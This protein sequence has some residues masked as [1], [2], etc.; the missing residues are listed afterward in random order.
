MKNLMLIVFATLAACAG[1]PEG[2]QPVAGFDAKRYTGKWYEIARLDNRFERGLDQITA[3]YNLSEDG[4]LHVV[5]SGR[6]TATNRREYAY[7]KACFTGSPNTGSLKVSFFGPFYGGYHIIELD[8][9]DYHYAMISGSGGRDYL[10]ILARS[11]NLN[12]TVLNFL[13]AK[14]KTLGFDTSKLIYPAQP[15]AE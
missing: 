8:K 4:G 14:A 6:N 10:W 2:L 11:P 13:T 12:G 5:N 9:A 15:E 7:G 1:V 3:E